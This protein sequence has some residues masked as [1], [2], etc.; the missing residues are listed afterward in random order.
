MSTNQNFNSNIVFVVLCTLEG[1]IIKIIKDNNNIFTNN[2]YLF[3]HE[4][5][6]EEDKLKYINFIEIVN[7]ERKYT[8][9]EFEISTFDYKSIIYVGCSVIQN[10]LFFVC[11]NQLW[12]LKELYINELPIF[13]NELINKKE[14]EYLKNHFIEQKK[15]EEI[16]QNLM[17]L[18]NELVNTKRLIYKS[19][20]ELQQEQERFRK[21]SEVISDFA[22]SFVYYPTHSFVVE[23]VTEAFQKIT[24]YSTSELKSLDDLDNLIVDE[25]KYR[26]IE[27]RNK[28][29]S[30]PSS[31]IQEYR[32]KTKSGEIRWLKDFR[33]SLLGKYRKRVDKIIG[34]T[35]DITEQKLASEKINKILE[36]L[37]IS[38]A[39]KDKFFSILAHDLRNPFNSILG[40]TNLLLLKF[41]SMDDS[42]KLTFIQAINQS[43]RITYELLENLLEW[44]KSQTNRIE[45]V[46]CV[47]N[48]EQLFTLI[49]EN[50]KLLLQSKNI[51]IIININ[52]KFTI[53]AEINM[54]QTVFRNLISNAIKYSYK[55]SKIILETTERNYYYYICIIDFGVGIP[56]ENRE[57]M[58]KINSKFSTKGTDNEQGTGLGLILCKEFVERNSG[59]I[60]V[61]SKINEG[62]KFTV[63]M[64]KFECTS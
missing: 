63:I 47:L 32:I 55:N 29:F 17:T 39:A 42:K 45:V 37:S 61:E 24:G 5:I 44:A 8:E 19:N 3:F 43:V 49:I 57:K 21:I 6:N 40:L 48:L 62:S 35:Q 15:E 36:Q 53:F 22:Y 20:I 58:F 12:Q 27:S 38:N 10:Y 34:G 2:E 33:Q 64:P 52:S 1:G 51:E 16:Y 23:W 25:D 54:M 28:L 7:T 50:L 26:V 30:T 31:D 56:V 18:N 13:Y 11:T 60:E 41:E 59:S 46:P 14:I 9:C 4:L